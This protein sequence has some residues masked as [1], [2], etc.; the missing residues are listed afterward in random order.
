MADMQIK[1]STGTKPSKA[2]Y[3]TEAKN[4]S[5]NDY[6]P[7]VVKDKNDLRNKRSASGKKSY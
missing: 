3:Y 5:R 1:S 7:N 2:G 4:L 6:A